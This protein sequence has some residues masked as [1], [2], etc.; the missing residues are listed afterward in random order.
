[1]KSLLRML[2]H[3]LGWV[4]LWGLAIAISLFVIHAGVD[5]LFSCPAFRR[6]AQIPGIRFLVE[7]TLNLGGCCLYLGVWGVLT[8]ALGALVS[9]EKPAAASPGVRREPPAPEP[10]QTVYATVSGKRRK[11]KQ[12]P[13]SRPEFY[14]HAGFRLADGKE[15]WFRIDEPEYRRLSEGRSGQLAYQGASYRS[16]QADGEGRSGGRQTRRFASNDEK[17]NLPL[18]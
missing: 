8:K 16:F 14:F 10:M 18:R 15:L 17:H 11:T 1:M 2:L 12:R 13:R 4:L 5:A 7:L 6:F 9:Q 3:L